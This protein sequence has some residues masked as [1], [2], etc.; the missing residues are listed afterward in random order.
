MT[1]SWQMF[2]WG[3]SVCPKNKGKPV[4]PGV[5]PIN[6]D[7]EE[8]GGQVPAGGR[9]AMWQHGGRSH[10]ASSLSLLPLGLREQIGGFAEADGL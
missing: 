3:G 8:G 6:M 10:L 2:A 5:V 4:V 1:E 9:S 7:P